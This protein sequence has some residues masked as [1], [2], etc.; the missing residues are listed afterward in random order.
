MYIKQSMK[1]K[2]DTTTTFSPPFH[3]FTIKV[4]IFSDGFSRYG[5]NIAAASA[6]KRQ[7]QNITLILYCSTMLVAHSSTALTLKQ[8]EK[9]CSRLKAMTF[10]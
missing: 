2:R 5:A 8:K 9:T 4:V 3:H 10:F 7:K 1:R 6:K